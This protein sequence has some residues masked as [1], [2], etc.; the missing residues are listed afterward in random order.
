VDV[1][2]N[3]PRRPWE[4][5]G[6]SGMKVLANGGLNLSQL[7]G[8]WAQAC[9]DEVGWGIG[10]GAE[11]GEEHDGVDAV[12]LYSLLETQ[13]VP[14]FYER[15]AEGI[16]G[17]W[18]RRMRASMATLVTQFSAD[19]AVREYVEHY[20]LPAASAYC[21]RAAEGGRLAL[22]LTQDR[23]QLSTCWSDIRFLQLDMQPHAGR[24]VVALKMDLAGLSPSLLRVQMYAE[25]LNGREAD[26]FDL[27]LDLAAQADS[28]LLYRGE[29]PD[30]RPAQAYTARVIAS[31]AAGWAVPLEVGLIVWRD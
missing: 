30:D 23:D 20:Y 7:D 10:D 14:A 16:P 3:T 9:T 12:Q 27:K 19:R 29:V 1:W 25:G 17:Q 28:L 5:S 21:A 15:D 31:D 2:V 11:H 26:I 6:T 22:Q 24:Y 18:I 8:W 4:A 13:V